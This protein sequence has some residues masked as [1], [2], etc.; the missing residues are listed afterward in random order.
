MQINNKLF[1]KE[2]QNLFWPLLVEQIFLT[3]IGNFNVFLFSLFNDQM[4]AA[5]GISDQLLNIFA[6]ITNI[7]VLGASILII[8]NAD[9]SR[10]SYVKS[11]LK[12]SVILNV[13]IAILIV[14]AVFLFNKD[15]LMLMQT[16]R[17]LLDETSIYIRIVSVSIIFLAMTS[18]MLGTLRAFGFVK[19]AVKVS[20][21]N[22]VL[23]I[24]GN[25]T[26]VIFNLGGISYIA[27][28]TLVSRLL[29]MLLTF[30]TLKSKIPELFDFKESFRK[31]P[32]K[33]EI[34]TLGIPS[35]MEQIS[36]N[37]SQTIITAIIASLGTIAVSSK[38]YTQTITSFIFSIGVAA[39]VAGN[40]VIG[41][42]YRN[43]DFEKIKNFGVINANRIS[44]IA[45]GVNL[46]LALL[47][48][49]LVGIFTKDPEITEIVTQ[50]LFFQILLDPMRVSNEILVNSLNVLKDVKFPV[51]VGIV[52]T[53]ILVI[54]LSYLLVNKLGMDLRAV[55]IIFI[56]DEALRRLLFTLRFKSGKWIKINEVDH[57]Y[58]I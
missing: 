22:T 1:T 2:Y 23:V 17:E 53:Y 4:V 27:I 41:N 44:L 21:I 40:L 50:L 51:I 28:A 34:L 36:Y 19:I 45:G 11:I 26:I 13:I 15:L 33:K 7:V 56:L 31:I 38:I 49:F 18:L 39:G 5:I 48:R 12:E 14:I 10:F 29:G 24:L 35:A 52:T 47:G 20:V 16:P 54:P 9:K 46:I 57:G 55:W 8:Q 42:Y 37:F 30:F 6:M 25:S 43:K 32:L 58:E 3:L